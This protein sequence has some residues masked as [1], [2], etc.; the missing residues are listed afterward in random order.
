MAYVSKEKKALIAA[1]LK[2]AGINKRLKYSLSV[3]H[4]STIVMKIKSGDVDFNGEFNYD[5][6][7]FGETP[8][9]S[10]NPYWYGD[11]FKGDSLEVLRKIFAALNLQGVE[12]QANF[13]K[14]DPMSDYFHVG[15]YVDVELGGGY[16]KPDYQYV[17]A[18][19][20]AA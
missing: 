3:R 10:V 6:L 14:S 4:H 12:G 5:K 15:W 13:D 1:A 11:H 16:G 8:K 7:R 9:A 20:K 2:A 18:A 19:K 17:P